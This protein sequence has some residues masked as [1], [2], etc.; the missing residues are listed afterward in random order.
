MKTNLNVTGIIVEY[1]PFHNGHIYHIDK[2]R[3]LTK[4]DVLIA[5]MSPHFVQRGEPAIIDKWTRTQIALDHGVDLV[6]E[7][8]THIALQSA[9]T[10]ATQAVRLLNM[11]KV[12]T[13]VYGSESMEK[14]KLAPIDKDALK[15][16]YSFAHAKNNQNLKANQILGAY[17]EVAA[18][19]FG[20]NTQRILR[21]KDYHDL[22]ISS[23]IASASAI[24]HAHFNQKNTEHTT[25]INLNST[26]IHQLKDYYPIL[27]YQILTERDQLNQYLIVD[28]GIE[29]LFIKLAATEETFDGFMKRA[30]SR[31]YTRSKI[32]RTLCHI[33]LKTPRNIEEPKGFRVLGMNQVGQK[34]L[35][36]IRKEAPIASQFKEYQYKDQESMAAFIYGIPYKKENAYLNR[37]V[38]PPII[39]SKS[40]HLPKESHRDQS[41]Q[42]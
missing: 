6:I 26:Q 14:P 16:G 32:Q 8:P 20:I 22:S 42:N 1:N 27:R 7:L 33:L 12:D 39:I 28:E 24:R 36:I 30:T 18:E 5:V 40:E 35:S 10:F 37:E 3:S 19:S 15:K 9:E 11:A 17:Y 23:K 41:D 13:I 34:Y 38:H 4:C 2:S 25:P 31:R 21:T 29:N